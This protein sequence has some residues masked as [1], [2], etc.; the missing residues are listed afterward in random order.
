[1]NFVAAIAK[2][3]VPS[4]SQIFIHGFDKM[5]IAIASDHAGYEE[6]ERLKPLL[7]ELGIQYEDLGTVSRG[8]T[9]SSQA[10]VTRNGWKRF[11]RSST[12]RSRNCVTDGDPA[13][14]TYERKT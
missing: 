8:S 9:P 12:K 1:V 10:A 14:R 11:A 4:L 3:D 5:K 13:K 6:K 2:R 7:N